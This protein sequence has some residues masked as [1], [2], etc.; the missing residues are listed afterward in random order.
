MEALAAAHDNDSIDLGICVCDRIESFCDAKCVD[1]E[2]LG[3][4]RFAR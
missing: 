3:V 2:F 1:V 4:E